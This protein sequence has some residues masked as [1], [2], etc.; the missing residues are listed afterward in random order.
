MKTLIQKAKATNIRKSKYKADEK[1][2][3]A[4]SVAWARDEI[5]IVQAAKAI[6]GKT[7]DGKGQ[8]IY[9]CLAKGLKEYYK[10]KIF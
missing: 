8:G 9:I 10:K 4:L 6:Y 5:G 3:M 7:A 2:L 1:E